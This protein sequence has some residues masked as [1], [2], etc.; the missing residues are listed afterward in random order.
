MKLYSPMLAKV[1]SE[2]DIKRKDM[3]FELKFD[4]TRA[5]CYKIGNK[6]KFL[7]RRKAWIEYRYPELQEIWKNIKKDCV[8]DGEIVVFNKKGLP[9]FS[10]LQEREH[11]DEKLRIKFLSKLFPA[12]YIVFD[13]LEVERKEIMRKPLLERKQILEEL[14]EE[15]ERI[16]KSVWSKEGKKL[17]EFAKN[18]KLEGI[19]AKQINSPYLQERSSYWLKIKFFK[20]LDCIIC[21]FTKGEGQR[22]KFFGALL[23]G[24]YFNGKLRYLGRVGTGFDEKT[25][26]ELLEKLRKLEI[27]QNPFDEFEEKPEILRK[28][29]WVKPKIVMEV[30]FMQLT[31]GLK[32]RAPVF[33]RVRDDKVAS[34]CVLSEEDVEN[35][36]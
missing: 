18:H 2:K 4:G 11:V 9:D 16:K 6:I 17:F 10:L 29:H 28:I 13:V 3:I 21:G 26:Q 23:A 20:S 22:E 24:I 31:S 34:E 1:G 25:M 5:I 27:N 12:R 7:N 14:I 35:L 32:M 33:L 30:K 19:M 15:G 36:R 8:L